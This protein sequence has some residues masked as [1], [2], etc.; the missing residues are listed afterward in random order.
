MEQTFYI[1]KSQVG[2][3]A[4]PLFLPDIDVFFN[5]DM[6]VAEATVRTL[7]EAGVDAVKGAVIH[8]ADIALDDE[9]LATYYDGETGMV[10]ER[11]RALIER[12]VIP[13]AATEDLFRMVR[14]ASSMIIRPALV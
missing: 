4:A 5:Q 13:L 10:E 2:G 7:L 14:N 3:G 8:R 12:K 9:S 1:G 11:Y 6:A